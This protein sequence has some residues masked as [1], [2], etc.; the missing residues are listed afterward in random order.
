MTLQEGLNP[1]VLEVSAPDGTIKR[2][3]INV[4]KLSASLAELSNL[5]LIPGRLDRAYQKKTTEYYATLGE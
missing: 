1:I 4:T 5:T 2:Y 3:T